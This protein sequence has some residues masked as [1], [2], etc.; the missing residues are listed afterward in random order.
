MLCHFQDQY[1]VY[2]VLAVYMYVCVCVCACVFIY[3]Q[4]AV[5]FH[6]L[7]FTIHFA[8]NKSSLGET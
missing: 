6:S 2:A 7:H 5:F 4:P 1:S 8:W 3:I